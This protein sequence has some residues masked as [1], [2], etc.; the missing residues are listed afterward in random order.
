MVRTLKIF[1]GGFVFG[2]VA[3]LIVGFVLWDPQPTVSS[4]TVHA[5]T[6]VST[7]TPTIP[8]AAPHETP[9]ATRVDLPRTESTSFPRHVTIPVQGV[10]AAD[11][12]DTFSE[13][14]GADRKHEA[15]DILAARGTPVIAADD[16][17]I[18]KLFTSE[19]G[20]LTLYHFDPTEEYSY[21]YAHL[22]RYADGIREGV[23]VKRGEVIGYVGTT[24][25]APPNTPHLHFGIFK[26]GA[27]KN[28]WEGVPINPYP[29]LIAQAR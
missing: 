18:K 16:G 28:W 8:S 21:Y 13:S 24:G 9:S 14:R 26:L 2:C 5:A 15:T 12:H 29:I 4:D 11:I 22:D 7:S 23:T 3:T 27:E 19:Q 1:A 10:S 20:G 25:N 6:A 17:L